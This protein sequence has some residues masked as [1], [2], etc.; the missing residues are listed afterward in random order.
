MRWTLGG[1]STALQANHVRADIKQDD[2]TCE[3]G[4]SAEYQATVQE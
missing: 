1:D 3:R 4:N 2:Q